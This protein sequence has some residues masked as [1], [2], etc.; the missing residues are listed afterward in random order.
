MI[1]KPVVGYDEFGNR[2]FGETDLIYNIENPEGYKCIG[3]DFNGKPVYEYTEEERT[4]IGYNS[5]NENI[6]GSAIISPFGTDENGKIIYGFDLN[7]RPI[8]GFTIKGEPVIEIIYNEK[9]VESFKISEVEKRNYI[10]KT[11]KGRPIYE[12]DVLGNP[13]VGYDKNGD[14]YLEPMEEREIDVYYTEY[15]N[16]S[17]EIMDKVKENVRKYV[18]ANKYPTYFDENGNPKFQ[19]SESL[20]N[21]YI[22]VEFK[23]GNLLKDI[24]NNE[25]K[26]EWISDAQI[27]MLGSYK[28]QIDSIERK[29]EIF[30]RLKNEKPT[31]PII[32]IDDENIPILGEVL[33][34]EEIE[35][36]PELIY[37]SQNASDFGYK[38]TVVNEENILDKDDFD[39]EKDFAKA[40][41]EL[42]KSLNGQGNIGRVVQLVYGLT[43]TE[44][45]IV[46]APES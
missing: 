33:I 15:D 7:N 17:K 24:E 37:S 21:E 30:D 35:D 36:T 41:Q 26:H 27:N 39:I 14:G 16:R 8:Y 22:E 40:E 1:I 6:Y 23:N 11:K 34:V 31:P 3:Y 29:K 28:V 44:E 19:N 38:Q 46:E 32:G 10:G 18:I 43:D 42:I 9:G 5:N 12:Y 20:L 13:I 25:N 45:L 2:V 4:V